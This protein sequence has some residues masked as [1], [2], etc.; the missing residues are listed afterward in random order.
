ME[1]LSYV[2][3]SLLNSVGL[4]PSLLRGSEVFSLGYLLG[5]KYF[6]VN[7]YE[8]KI[9]LMDIAWGQDIFSWVFRGC[10]AF[11]LG[12]FVGPKFYDFQ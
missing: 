9:F 3:W 2:D 11:S 8:S 4:V 12:Y 6:H 1:T 5:P 7:M 10:K